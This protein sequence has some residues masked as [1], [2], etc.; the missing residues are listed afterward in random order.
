LPQ[1]N[2]NCYAGKSDANGYSY[3][4]IYAGKSDA[5]GYGNHYTA[6]ISYAYADADAVADPHPAS[7]DA[8]AA[9]NATSSAD[10]VSEW[11]KRLKRVTK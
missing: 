6:S 11:R 8:K 10:T 9:T 1:P 5:D 7:A 4:Y 2:T 3:G